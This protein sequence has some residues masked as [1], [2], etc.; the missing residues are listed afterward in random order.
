[1]L[2]TFS[3]LIPLALAFAYSIWHSS[4][5]TS[6]ITLDAADYKL[7]VVAEKLSAYFNARVSEVDVMARNSDVKTM[8]F[9]QMR[10]YLMTMLSNKQE[11]YE[12][13]IV[14]HRDGSFNNTSGG[15]PFLKMLR[16]FDDKS[17]TAQVKNIRRRDYWQI[18]VGNN[19][20]NSHQV[21][22]SNPMISYTTEV[23]QVVVASSVHDESGKVRG[24][25]GA[26]LPWNKIQKKINYLKR[27]LDEEL[28]GDT[29]LALISKD[30]TYWYH[31]DDKK[32][33]HL[34][35]NNTGQYVLSKNGEKIAVKTN[36]KDTDRKELKGRVN[37]I[38]SGKRALITFKG[39]ETIHHIYTPID[40]SGYVLEMAIADKVLMS[41]TWS[42]VKVLMV[43]FMLSI[44]IG[45]IFALVLTKKVTDPLLKFT[46]AIRNEDDKELDNISIQSST[47]EFINLFNVFDQMISRARK[48]EEAIKESENRF[49]LA[50]KG[51]NDGLWDWNMLTDEVYYSV[52]WKEML[53]YK[54]EELENKLTTWEEL[55]DPA[56]KE[57][58]YQLIENYLSGKTDSFEKEIRMRHKDGHYVDIL[59]RAFAERTEEG[60][61]V[62]LVGTHID[63]TARKELEVKQAEQNIYLENR[64]KERTEELEI[65]NEE[66]KTAKDIAES[67]SQDKSQFLANMSHE[68]R[69][70]MNGIIGLTDLALRTRLEP[71]QRKYLSKVRSSADIL[72]HILNDILDFSKIEAGKLSLE[73]HSF[74]IR[75]IIENIIELFNVKA[76]EKNISL[77]VNLAD[78]LPRY[79]IGDP[80]RVSQV[81]SNLISNAIKFT[82]EG[83]VSLDIKQ[84]EG[85]VVGITVTDTGVGISLYDQHRLFESFTQA[86]S[87]TSRKYGGTGLGLAISKSLVGLMEGFIEIESEEGKGSCFRVE[88]HLPKSSQQ[89]VDDEKASDHVSKEHYIS[90]VLKD[91]K[92][93]L[94]EDVLTNQFIAEELLT[95]AGLKVEIA[96][97]GKEAL[98]RLSD[99]FDL[100][101]MDIQMPVMDGYESTRKIRE[102]DQYKE[103]PVIAMT[104]NAMKEDKERC[105]LAGMN[106]HISKPLDINNVIFELERYFLVQ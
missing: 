50:M 33:M 41:P 78:D 97:N 63:I 95:Q 43:V 70:P 9:S 46:S 4:D 83:S 6:D 67:A 13:F 91:K 36:I 60:V 22:I 79:V 44:F 7:R 39:D 26:S 82:E 54:E 73:K 86:D 99:D 61:P 28:G 25:L 85:D 77:I 90:Q 53:G 19:D 96:N 84:L 100:I 14:G 17:A 2:L 37:D 23:K 45:S 18:T 31:W 57:Q 88:I 87:S 8:D 29:K 106:G 5:I 56:Y 48:R 38:L 62:R 59:S 94:V 64:V 66:L 55:V 40:S 15:N 1:M 104:A 30:G 16:T 98:E 35:K 20:K 75:V 24:L 103:I 27:L 32:I 74:E 47:K 80:V 3:G 71:M 72:L 76:A 34:A 89:S 101:L 21:Y 92:V 52:R 58:T 105:A 81:V 68:I 11:H 42:L 12:K 65:L 69:T 93:L 51:A 10:P 102:L 49:A